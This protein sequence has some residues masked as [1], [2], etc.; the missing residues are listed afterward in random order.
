MALSIIR[1]Q[2]A[3]QPV[4]PRNWRVML[5]ELPDHLRE[6]WEERAAIIQYDGGEP[7]ATAERR[8]FDCVVQDFDDIPSI[9]KTT[10]LKLMSRPAVTA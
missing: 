9:L 5:A 4:I 8:A 2:S 6:V 1:S 7:R 3:A 10:Q